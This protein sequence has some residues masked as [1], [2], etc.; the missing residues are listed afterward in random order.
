MYKYIASKLSNSALQYSD[1]AILCLIVC[2]TPTRARHSKRPLPIF[3]ISGS[4]KMELQRLSR[5]EYKYLYISRELSAIGLAAEIGVKTSAFYQELVQSQFY[6]WYLYLLSWS[7]VD[8][9]PTFANQSPCCFSTR[10]AVISLYFVPALYESD[11][12]AHELEANCRVALIRH[13][14]RIQLHF[15]FEAQ[16]VGVRPE[17]ID[18]RELRFQEHIRL[19]RLYGRLFY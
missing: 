1:S 13:S 14:L 19:N 2:W 6:A 4:H 9:S 15:W 8:Y 7:D 12:T 11:L 17:W 10:L 3:I 16:Q 5:Y 18:C